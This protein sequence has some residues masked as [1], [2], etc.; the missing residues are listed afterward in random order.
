MVDTFLRLDAVKTATGLGRSKIYSLVS[1]GRFPRPVKLDG[2][3]IVAWV[4]SEIAAWQKAQIEARDTA[5]A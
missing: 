3:H 2:G 1:E 5:A 4:A